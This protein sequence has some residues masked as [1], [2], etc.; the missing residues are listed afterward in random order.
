MPKNLEQE[1][2]KRAKV[3]GLKGER[4]AAYIHGTLAKIKARKG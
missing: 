2:M 3:L 4:R 1:L